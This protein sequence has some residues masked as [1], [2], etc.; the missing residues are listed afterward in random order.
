[1]LQ[2]NPWD[3]LSL[4]ALCT[5]PSRLLNLS[6]DGIIKEGC[7]ADLVVVEAFNWAGIFKAN[8]KRKIFI[9]GKCYQK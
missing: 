9:K 2:L 3:R 6:W 1:M 7:P 5:A 4:S 8:L